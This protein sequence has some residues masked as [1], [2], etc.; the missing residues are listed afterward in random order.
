MKKFVT[1]KFETD[2]Q[3]EIAQEEISHSYE[4]HLKSS[5]YRCLLDGNFTELYHYLAKFPDDYSIVKELSTEQLEN[6]Y[7]KLGETYK[8]LEVEWG[9]LPERK[10]KTALAN[11][12]RKAF[13]VKNIIKDND[14]F[15]T[16]K[17][18]LALIKGNNEDLPF[19]QHFGNHLNH[20]VSYHDYLL[21]NVLLEK[22]HIQFMR[23]RIQED[24]EI[25]EEMLPIVANF[26][27]SD[28]KNKQRF[29][30]VFNDQIKYE[31]GD[32]AETLTAL[33][34]KATSKNQPER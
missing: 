25:L 18:R 17:T 22:D 30:D 19:M 31:S 29:T 10:I 15:V 27:M 13:Y 21:I 2:I 14:E 20:V 24:K 26:I 28:T 33:I 4:N 32:I 3:Y 23:N 7:K 8:L 34:K 1:S 12:T 6:L 5:G 16:D 11:I 9:N